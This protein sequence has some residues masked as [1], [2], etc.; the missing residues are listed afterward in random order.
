[1]GFVFWTCIF[2]EYRVGRA[3][4]RGQRG[5]FTCWWGPSH[6]P[7]GSCVGP[8]KMIFTAQL[9]MKTLSKQGWPRQYGPGSISC[10]AARAVVR[11]VV[12]PVPARRGPSNACGTTRELPRQAFSSRA[13][14]AHHGSVP[15]TAP[16]GNKRHGQAWHACV[17]PHSAEQGMPVPVPH[18][19]C[20][21]GVRHVQQVPG[22]DLAA[23]RVC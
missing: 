15:R 2:S 12:A 7:F 23:P 1:M 8:T 16:R 20:C 19:A 3:K 6:R 21:H 11:R 18:H 13:T 22:T 17:V 5:A 9:V 10:L 14:R 4:C